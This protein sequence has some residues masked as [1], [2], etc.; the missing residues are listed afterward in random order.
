MLAWDVLYAHLVSINQQN[1]IE[2]FQKCECRTNSVRTGYYYRL[3]DGVRVQRFKCKRCGRGYSEATGTLCFAQKKRQVNY[4]IYFG[5]CS[6]VSQ[7]RVAKGLRINRKTVARKLQ[8]LANWAKEASKAF[9]FELGK[10]PVV[11][12]DDM[13]TFEI[14][15]C[16]PLSI[17]MIVVPKSRWILDFRVAVMPA[18]GRLAAISR[19][20]YGLRKDERQMARLDLFS[21]VK[22]Y[23]APDV[24]VK[25]DQNPHYVKILRES[26]PE[27]VHKAFKGRRGCVTGQGEL[28]RGGFDPLFSF[29]HTAAMLRANINRLFRRTWCT[30]KHR[31]YLDQHIRLYVIFH[32]LYLL[33]N[34]RSPQY[35]SLKTVAENQFLLMST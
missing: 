29:N 23:L 4:P 30:T 9:N 26:L 5:L 27:C 6:G 13:E 1:P 18:K 14:S 8:F 12:F 2:P 32:N 11:E 33:K 10:I 3:S 19:N 21:S 34:R 7:R 15:K 16:L 31:K 17:P 35:D 22:N 28:K 25:S 24:V 20:K